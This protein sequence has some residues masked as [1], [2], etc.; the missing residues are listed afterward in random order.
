MILRMKCSL[1][2]GEKWRACLIRLDRPTQYVIEVENGE[3]V[4]QGYEFKRHQKSLTFPSIKSMLCPNCGNL[5]E[6]ER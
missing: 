3:V 4:S 2:C 1:Q 6:V 5:G